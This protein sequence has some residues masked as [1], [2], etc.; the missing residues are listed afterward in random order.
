MFVTIREFPDALAIRLK[1]LTR[2][3]TASKAVLAACEAF[4][5][6]RQHV[7]ELEQKIQELERT[8][9]ALSQTLSEAREA[10]LVLVERTAQPD[11]G[12]GKPPPERASLAG[13]YLQSDYVLKAWSTSVSPHFLTGHVSV[14][15]DEAGRVH[16]AFEFSNGGFL[17]ASL[18]P[19]GSDM[20]VIELSR[21]SLSFNPG[22]E[23]GTFSLEFFPT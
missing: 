4:I 12:A 7:R 9:S 14:P 18:K 17:K 21:L 15:V 16:E 23:E 10:A 19:D 13:R 11:L 3:Q 2:T 5:P 22:E 20:Q 1:L 8:N 6:M